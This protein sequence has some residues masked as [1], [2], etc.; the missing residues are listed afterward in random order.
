MI[1]LFACAA[2]IVDA[3]ASTYTLLSCTLF[4][5]EYTVRWTEREEQSVSIDSKKRKESNGIVNGDFKEF[6]G[7]RFAVNNI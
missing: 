2:T 7:H 5:E 1:E 6:S 4:D 3:T